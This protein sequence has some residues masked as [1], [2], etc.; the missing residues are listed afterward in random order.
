MD[1]KDGKPTSVTTVCSPLLLVVTVRC[2]AKS[3]DVNV[4]V[5]RTAE[6]G[7]ANDTPPLVS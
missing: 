4:V 2:G 7:D 6:R 1:I 3:P 5:E